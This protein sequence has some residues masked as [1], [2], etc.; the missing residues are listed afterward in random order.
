MVEYCQEKDLVVAYTFYQLYPR[1]LF[2]S[3]HQAITKRGVNG[4]RY[5]FTLINKRFRNGIPS[6][7]NYSSADGETDHNL[8]LANVNLRLKIH[9]KHA[10]PSH[11]YIEKLQDEQY[12][13]KLYD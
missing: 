9:K 5:D 4:I 13:K 7:K 3:V 1:R 12:Q 11:I 2:T 8:L 10:Q 6:V